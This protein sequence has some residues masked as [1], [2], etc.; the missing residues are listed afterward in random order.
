M[1][2]TLVIVVVGFNFI[3]LFNEI[4]EHRKKKSLMQQISNSKVDEGEK[5]GEDGRE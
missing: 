3:L 5:K 4:N 2:S 1:S